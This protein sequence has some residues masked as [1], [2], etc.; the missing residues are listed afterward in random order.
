MKPPRS[1][2]SV[3]SVPLLLLPVLLLPLF[4]C[5]IAKAQSQ[6]RLT[7]YQDRRKQAVTECANVILHRFSRVRFGAYAG[8]N[9]TIHMFGSNREIFQ[10]KKCMSEK[11]FAL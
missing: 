1:L 5:P 6:D 10:F 7:Q 9:G 4:E 3:L 2:A 11:G 8:P